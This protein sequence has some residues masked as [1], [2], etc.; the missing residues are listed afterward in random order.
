M[1]K[2]RKSK[3]SREGTF[4]LSAVQAAVSKKSASW[5][6]AATPLT[7]LSEEER[8]SFLGLVVTKEELAAT[9]AAIKAVSQLDT[10][11]MAAA[12]P[13]AVDWRNNGGSF[14]TPIKNQQACGSCVSFGTLA[15]I[16]SRMNIACRTPGTARDYAEAFL[17]YCGC[18]N[19]C[20]TGWNFVPALDFCKNTGVAQEA[21]FPYTPVDQACKPGVVPEFKINGHSSVL[22]M[23]DRKS[24]IAD[25]GPVVAGLAVYQ[26]FYAYHSGVYRHVTGGLAGYHCV[27]VVGY[28]DGRSCWIAKNSWGT[29]WGESG[30]FNIGYGECGI[31]SSF[32]FFE[33]QVACTPGPLTDCDRYLAVLRRVILLARTNPTL[34]RCLQ[35]VC[36]GAGPLCPRQYQIIVNS[37]S[38]ILRRC[39]KY[40]QPFC[41]AIG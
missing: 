15:T 39:P 21:S 20:G 32:A 24:A 29:G 34:R 17:F 7:A 26:D 2:Q 8:T 3:G 22:S 19:C 37:V 25:R 36:R 10:L 4:S 9:E 16:E 23:A 14:V 1:A 6:A 41:R 30:F 18:G 38:A 28:D 40:R 27:S 13:A 33:P 35:Q 5:Q 12:A 31:D 11:R